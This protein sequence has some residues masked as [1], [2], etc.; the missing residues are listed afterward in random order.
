MAFDNVPANV[1]SLI[2]QVG[3]VAPEGLEDDVNELLEK[4]RSGYC[5]TCGTELG[6]DTLLFINKR[7]IVAAYCG[8][9]CASDMAVLGWLEEHYDDIM[10]NVKFRSGEVK[11]DEAPDEQPEP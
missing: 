3:I 5:M 11:P 4:I 7:G 10:T 2:E 8:G 6:G 9:A 1:G